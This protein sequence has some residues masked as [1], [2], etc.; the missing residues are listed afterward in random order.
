MTV[1]DSQ[2]T[3]PNDIATKVKSVELLNKNEGNQGFTT[4][5]NFKQEENNNILTLYDDKGFYGDQL[6]YNAAVNYQII[7]DK[8]IV[9]SIRVKKG[10]W[11]DLYDEEGVRLGIIEGGR[12]TGHP[13]NPEFEKVR[14]ITLTPDD[15][16]KGTGTMFE[17]SDH[18]GR[19]ITF[20]TPGIYT[21][22]EFYPKSLFINE[23]FEYYLYDNVNH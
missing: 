10:Y 16:Y 13:H 3:I 14:K 2:V 20:T 22:L 4:R 9:G 17:A 7:P 8:F 23:G 5:I 21:N 19:A 6:V 11:V 18:T 12:S 15:W 1:T